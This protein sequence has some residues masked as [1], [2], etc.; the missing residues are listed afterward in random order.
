MAVVPGVLRRPRKPRPY[1]PSWGL[2]LPGHWP[3][4]TSTR[5]DTPAFS[6]FGPVCPLDS[7]R[8]RRTVQPPSFPIPF[9][10]CALGHGEGARKP[11]FRS[12]LGTGCV[13]S[14]CGSPS[15][16]LSL[17]VHTSPQRCFLL[18]KEMIWGPA[19]ASRQCLL[20][21]IPC[22]G[23]AGQPLDLASDQPRPKGRPARPGGP[24]PL[25]KRMAAASAHRP[26][27]SRWGVGAALALLI[28]TADVD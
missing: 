15:L 13:T 21:P 27:R 8:P 23:G 25:M 26:G 28:I 18:Y 4:F 9:K 2:W 1:A 17:P 11:G 14:R 20:G 5:D 10:A 24:G 22:G 6:A 16:G 7:F 3:F 19:S 12:R